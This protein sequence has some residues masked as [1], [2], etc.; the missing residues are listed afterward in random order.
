MFFHNTTQQLETTVHGYS[1]KGCSEKNSQILGKTLVS[2]S[3]F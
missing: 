2:D 3:L 1:V